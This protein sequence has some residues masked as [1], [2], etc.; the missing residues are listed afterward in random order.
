MGFQR[1]FPAARYSGNH[2]LLNKELCRVLFDAIEQ[3]LGQKKT[4]INDL[5]E[6]SLKSV[7]KC[8]QCETT[9]IKIDNFLD[10]SLPV[11]SEH[12]KIYN[13]SIEMA[14]RN[15]LKPEKLEKDNQYF[16]EKCS[17]KA[18]ENFL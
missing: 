18:K 12:E 17:K 3:S 13:S 6:G 1:D 7:A 11:R 16:C 9:S 8:L 14:L 5:Y 2:W 10:L 15:I 4:F